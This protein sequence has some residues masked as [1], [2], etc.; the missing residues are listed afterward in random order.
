MGAELKNLFRNVLAATGF[1]LT[2]QQD[3]GS[4]MQL[5][6]R[7]HPIRTSIPLIR[8]GGSGDGGYLVP[9]DLEGLVACF[10]PGVDDRATFESDLISRGIPCFLADPSVDRAP[11]TGELVRFDKQYLGVTNDDV[12]TTLDAWVRRYAPGQGD[13]ILQIDIEG[14]EWPVLL[15]VS[16]ETL[17]RFRIIVIEIHFLERIIHK[18]AFFMMKAVME[19]LLSNFYVVHIHPNNY[20]RAPTAGK[21][22]L[23]QFLE[24]TFLRRDRAEPQGYATQFPHPLDQANVA[25]R[26]DYALPKS[27]FRAPPRQVTGPAPNSR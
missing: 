14:W 21:L 20:S 1:T 23:P 9:D 3:P 10:S 2:R 8:L 18:F 12:T 17:K 7:L 5:I 24:F 15:N 16:D 13:L 26:P 11:I 22:V 4:I 27:W 19:R 6:E 25:D